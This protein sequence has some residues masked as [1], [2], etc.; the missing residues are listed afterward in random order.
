MSRKWLKERSKDAWYKLAKKEG[1]RSRASF[2]LLQLDEKH[3]LIFEGAR[4]VDLG[5]APGG[6]SQVAVELAGP[7]G[8]VVGVDLDKMEPLEGATLMRGDMT[9]PDTVAKVMTAIGGSADVVISDMSPNISG[10]YATDHAR[11]VFLVENAIAF[12]EKVLVKNGDMVFKVFEGDM[13][14]LLL[15]RVK[16]RFAEVRVDHPPA[17]RK[18]SSE[19]YVIAKRFKGPGKYAAPE[20]SPE[21][22]EGD[23]MPPSRKERKVP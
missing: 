6:W 17:S 18:Q 11:S 14:P 4:V 5:A 15:S 20:P 10:A 8:L 13:F 22:K 12:A 2:K 21:W 1:W 16:Q 9:S 3:Q 23:A 19:A 7:D